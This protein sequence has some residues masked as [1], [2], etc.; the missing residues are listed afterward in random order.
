[1]P[2]FAKGVFM[3][4]AIMIISASPVHAK[5]YLFRVSCADE[6]F[7][8]EWMPGSSDPGKDYF[9]IA[10]GDSNLDCSIYDYD[11]TKDSRLPLRWCSDPGGIIRGFPP[12]LILL[13]TSHCR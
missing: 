9:R 13:G 6:A 2:D 3:S 12:L 5:A 10:T 1:M 11:V 7:V 4:V 8:A